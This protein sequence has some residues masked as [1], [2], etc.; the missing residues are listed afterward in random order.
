MRCHCQ[1]LRT[2]KG[3]AEL[4]Y[5]AGPIMISLYS[6]KYNVSD[7]DIVVSQDSAE[8]M[9]AH[10]KE[11]HIQKYRQPIK[12]MPNNITLYRAST[13]NVCNAYRQVKTIP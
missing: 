9:P 10:S 11:R 12:I 6:K 4:S 7:V 2:I 3:C 1:T 5:P 13:W 8:I